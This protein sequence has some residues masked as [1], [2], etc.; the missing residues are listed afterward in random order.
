MIHLLQADEAIIATE[1]TTAPAEEAATQPDVVA[2]QAEQAKELAENIVSGNI[3]VDAL[4]QKLIDWAMDAGHHIL[5]A[6]IVYIIGH[7][8]IKFINYLLAKTLERRKVEASVQTFLRSFVNIVLK[9]L[10]FVSVIGT[11]GFNTTSFA[12]LLASA[13]V[14]IGMALSGNLQNLAG[15]IIILFLKPFKVGDWI[16]AQGTAGSVVAIHIFHT[17]LLTADGKQIY[18]PN[19]ALSSGNITNYNNTPTRQVECA[20][21]VEYGQDI[22]KAR[23][24]L[25]EMVKT[26]ERILTDP[27]PVVHLKELADSSVNLIL[28][29]RVQNDDYWA[30]F[31]KLN[32]QIYKTFNAKGIGFPFPQLTIHQAND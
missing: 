7:Y 1:A 11:L 19:G 3:Q 6:L 2:Q 32:E 9:I 23:A 14:A 20:I 29:C 8:V 12:A 18:V 10:L 27:A 15:G 26:D 4:I 17:I 28:R 16:E 5:M 13:G 31:F 21:S 22:D 24:T 25:L 30:V